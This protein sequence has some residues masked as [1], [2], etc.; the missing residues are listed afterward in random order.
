MP[1]ARAR[2]LALSPPAELRPAHTLLNGQ[3]FGWRPHEHR[4][5]EYVG[6]LGRRVV[7][8]RQTTSGTEFAAMHGRPE[9]LEEELIDYFQLRTPLS[10]LYAQWA[11]AGCRRMEAISRSLPGLRILRQ[12][13]CECLFSFICSSNNNVPRI[14]LILDR[15]RERPS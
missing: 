1:V 4:V 11:S 15:M 14:T 2:L 12:E 7:S 5:D 6:V 10:S 8:I 3:C 13:P 9:G